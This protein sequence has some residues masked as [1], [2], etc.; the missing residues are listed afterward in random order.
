MYSDG[1]AGR[2]MQR[3]RTLAPPACASVSLSTIKGIR[4]ALRPA[5]V[6][7]ARTG[8]L[9]KKGM[10]M[11]GGRRGCQPLRK[12]PL[13]LLGGQ[14]GMLHQSYAEDGRWCDWHAGDEHRGVAGVGRASSK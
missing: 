9:L 12:V 1:G 13:R 4:C 10:D 6:A 2:Q 8:L 14:M 5:Y 11:R 3:E 7:V